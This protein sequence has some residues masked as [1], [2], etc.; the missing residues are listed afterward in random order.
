MLSLRQIFLCGMK[1]SWDKDGERILK[2]DNTGGRVVM[3]GLWLFQCVGVFISLDPHS[4]YTLDHVYNQLWLAWI[5]LVLN[6][7]EQKCCL[8]QVVS[9]SKALK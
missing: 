6:L 5:G 2:G 9:V 7:P 3:L 1:A 8:G 4:A